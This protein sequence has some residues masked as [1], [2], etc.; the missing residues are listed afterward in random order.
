MHIAP[1][2]VP[3]FLFHNTFLYV[4]NPANCCILGWHGAMNSLN[5]NGQQQVITYMFAS[6]SDYGLFNNFNAKTGQYDLPA[7][8]AD[9]HGLSHEVAEWLQDP[10][11]HNFVPYWYSPAAPQYGCNNY[12]EAGDPL[13]GISPNTSASGYHAQEIP[14]APWFMRQSPSTSLNG[15]ATYTYPDSG[16]QVDSMINSVFKAAGQPPL[17]AGTGF[18]TYSPSC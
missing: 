12:L 2:T 6:Y 1:T 14:I 13:V 10:F 15:N 8:I 7:P 11:V 4:G 9:I 18:Q 3:I 5:G 16:R 17:P